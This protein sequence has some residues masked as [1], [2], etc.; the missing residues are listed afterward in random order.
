MSTKK[1]QEI[2]D[3]MLPMLAIAAEEYEGR[4]PAGYPVVIDDVAHGTVGFELDPSY[5]LH[6]TTDG[7]Q[8][9]A[10]VY[11]RLPR[12][13]SRAYAARQKYAGMP[14]SDQ[15]PLSPDVTDQELRNLI[16]E[17]KN[18]FNLMPGMLYITED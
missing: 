3:R 6:I 11:K 18:A 10:D 1:L 16:G 14:E 8:L 7:E 15:R 13:D 17:L 2:R 12:I 5:A 4:V 9:Y